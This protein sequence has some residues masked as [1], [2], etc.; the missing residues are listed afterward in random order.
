M[1]SNLKCLK[2]WYSSVFLLKLLQNLQG[3]PFLGSFL[4]LPFTFSIKVMNTKP[5]VSK[6]D[7]MKF[8]INGYKC[9]K[10][11]SP[12]LIFNEIFIY[13]HL[14]LKFFFYLVKQH[15]HISCIYLMLWDFMLINLLFI[16]QLLKINISHLNSHITCSLCYGYFIDATTTTECLHTCK[17]LSYKSQ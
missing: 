17:M 6:T 11:F 10:S 7:Y 15:L 14:S 13:N 8:D 1:N 9:I 4:Y 5:H 2:T 16:F 3:F 12:R